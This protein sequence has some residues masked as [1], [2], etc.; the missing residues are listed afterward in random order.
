[1]PDVRGTWITS[2]KDLGHVAGCANLAEFVDDVVGQSDMEVYVDVGSTYVRVEHYG[3]GGQPSQMTFDYPFDSQDILDWVYHIEN[4][5]SIRY[6]IADDIEQMLEIPVYENESVDLEDDEIEELLVDKV[7]RV[8][9]FVQDLLWQR[10][11][12][13][14]GSDLLVMDPG[15]G[16]LQ[17][18]A[19]HVWL[20]PTVGGISRPYQPD[21]VQRTVAKLYPD[22]RI[23]LK[24][25]A[26]CEAPVDVK[27]IDLAL[28]DL[29]IVD[30]PT[31][32]S[33]EA[34]D[35]YDLA[36]GQFWSAK[37]P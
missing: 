9:A 37:S 15:G 23:A 13:L 5:D 17:L 26:T 4:D 1:M 28:P 25:S 2:K 8:M 24:W 30:L 33:Q 19:S 3:G 29:L 31:V 12:D 21:P 6:E 7:E 32:D 34:I 22:G 36:Y 14:D 20:T 27:G 35:L 11:I 18:S 10:R 16:S